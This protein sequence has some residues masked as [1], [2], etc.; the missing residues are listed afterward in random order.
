M[1]ALLAKK[2]NPAIA[3][4]KFALSRANGTEVSLATGSLCCIG[5]ATHESLAE[6]AR[7]SPSL[8][9]FCS[10]VSHTNLAETVI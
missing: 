10:P 9:R 8:H 2:K 5:Y 1:D 7:I 6:P 3:G 4:Q